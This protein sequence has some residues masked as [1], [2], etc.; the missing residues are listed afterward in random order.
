MQLKYKAYSKLE[1]TIS[2]FQYYLRVSVR[3]QPCVYTMQVQ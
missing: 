1:E 2:N 3:I